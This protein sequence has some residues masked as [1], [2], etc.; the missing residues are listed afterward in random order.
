MSAPTISKLVLIVCAVAGQRSDDDQ[1]FAGGSPNR[2]GGDRSIEGDESS[3]AMDRQREEVEIGELAGP[4]DAVMSRDGLVEQTHR[5]RPELMFRARA[6]ACQL[7]QRHRGRNGVRVRRLRENPHASVLGDRA[8]CPAAL[9]IGH[10][11][12]S[13]RAMIL[14]ATIEQRDDDVDVEQR[15]HSVADLGSQPV[16]IVVRCVPSVGGDRLEPEELLRG[17]RTARLKRL[18]KPDP[19]E[20]RDHLTRRAFLPSRQVLGEEQHIVVEIQGGSHT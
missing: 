1:V 16:D 8:R 19:C 14:V 5:I 20:F 7:R 11:P 13:R 17:R 15:S 3:A 10:Q 18:T 4:V 6:G 2:V 9:C 12:R